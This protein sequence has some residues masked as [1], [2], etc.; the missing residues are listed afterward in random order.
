MMKGCRFPVAFLTGSHAITGI[1][2][3]VRRPHKGA[4][5]YVNGDRAVEFR[6]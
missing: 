2:V 1:F 5:E 6:A 3:K 4:H